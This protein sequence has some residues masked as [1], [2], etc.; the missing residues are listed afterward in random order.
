MVQLRQATPAGRP[1]WLCSG[2]GVNQAGLMG[3]QPRGMVSGQP[4][5]ICLFVAGG[6]SSLIEEKQNLH[7]KECKSMY[8]SSA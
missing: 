6:I 4:V 5:E 8:A 1:R 3:A 2:S 7:L